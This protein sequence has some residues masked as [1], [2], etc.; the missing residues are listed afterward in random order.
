ML[1]LSFFF[2]NGYQLV[3]PSRNY[4]QILSCFSFI[5][6]STG[7]VVHYKSI[8][9]GLT[10]HRSLSC[11]IIQYSSSGVVAMSSSRVMAVDF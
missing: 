6:S 3:L 7:G 4:T 8:R 10:P 5:P 2:S 9:L 1:H 11:L